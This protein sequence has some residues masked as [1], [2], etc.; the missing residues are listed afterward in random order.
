MNTLIT[1]LEED[2]ASWAKDWAAKHNTSVSKMLGTELRE[3]MQRER[4][5]NRAMNR[6]F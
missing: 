3:K 6:Y 2:V 1:S 5:Y 4:Y